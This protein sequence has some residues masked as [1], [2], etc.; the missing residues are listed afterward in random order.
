MFLASA[1]GGLIGL[2]LGLIGLGLVATA[3]GIGPAFHAFGLV[4]LPTLAFA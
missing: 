4:L 1:S 2:G 3:T